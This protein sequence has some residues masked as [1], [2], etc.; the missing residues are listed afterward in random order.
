MPRIGEKAESSL[1]TLNR[2]YAA[3]RAKTCPDRLG[4]HVPKSFALIARS[5]LFP[6]SF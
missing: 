2:K 3:P 4:L 5:T 6:P 1:E